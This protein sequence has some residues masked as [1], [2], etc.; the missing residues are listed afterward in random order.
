[1]CDAGKT[2]KISAQGAKADKMYENI[3]KKGVNASPKLAFGG[4]MPKEIIYF[5]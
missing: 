3:G 2:C 5:S 4:A 1:M